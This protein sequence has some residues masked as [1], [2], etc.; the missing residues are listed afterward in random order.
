[1]TV[2]N[3]KILLSLNKLYYLLLGSSFSAVK[4]IKKKKRRKERAYLLLKNRQRRLNGKIFKTKRR[5]E[6]TD[7]FKTDGAN[8]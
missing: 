6:L 7:S 4:K 8:V 5:K 2:K 1:L 3:N